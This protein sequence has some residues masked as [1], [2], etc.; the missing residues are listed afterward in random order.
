[1]PSPLS[2]LHSSL[3]LPN[4]TKLLQH[5][6]LPTP[7]VP[8][9]DTNKYHFFPICPSSLQHPQPPHIHIFPSPVPF[10][11]SN[12]I[13]NPQSLT[14]TFLF[15]P[16]TPTS[17]LFSLLS[18][19]FFFHLSDKIITTT[20][21]Y[22]HRHPRTSQTSLQSQPTS[23]SKGSASTPKTNHGLTCLE[24]RSRNPA[25]I[26]VAWLQILSSS[27]IRDGE[28]SCASSSKNAIQSQRPSFS[29][30]IFPGALTRSR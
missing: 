2:P 7:L 23:S 8:F 9:P 3:S 21:I 12:R 6:H 22:P 5:Q 19:P 1:L 24:I 14:P 13:L 16:T 4:I 20:T 18:S 17:K 28:I 26:L 27:S 25:S 15:F 11:D 29:T 10:Y 30:W